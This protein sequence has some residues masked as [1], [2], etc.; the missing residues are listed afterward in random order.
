MKESLKEVYAW[1]GKLGQTVVSSLYVLFFSCH[2][3]SR[4]MKKEYQ[5]RGGRTATLLGNGPSLRHILND[6]PELLEGTDIMVVN[7]FGNAP[8]FFKLKP[9]YYIV[10]DPI[11]YNPN[12]RLKEELTEGSKA[13]EIN[14]QLWENLQNVDWEMTMFIPRMA[15]N[16]VKEGVQN[17][18][19][20]FV[21]FQACRVL[22]FEWFQNWMYRHNKGCPCSRNIALPAMINLINL[23]YK[24]IYLYGIDFSWIKNLDVDVNNGLTYMNDRHFYSQEEIR[25]FGKGYYKRMLGILH[26]DLHGT[27]Q[28]A[29]Y[30]LSRGVKMV[31]RTIGSYVDSFEYENPDN[32]KQN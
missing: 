6:K 5:D 32:I 4:G 21:V 26:E 10:L 13:A 19:V 12:Y 31:N 15:R 25:H 9:R 28:I 14:R 27:D 17:P 3:I 22:G 7:Y 16:V 23:G 8:E 1:L 2:W 30:A 29:K 24:T 20:K 18:H 11:Y